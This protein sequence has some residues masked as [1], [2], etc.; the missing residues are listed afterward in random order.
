MGFLGM[1]EATRGPIV[2]LSLTD[3]ANEIHK[4][5]REKPIQ[6]SSGPLVHLKLLRNTDIPSKI[7]HDIVTY[8]LTG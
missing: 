2:S 6:P 7:S 4:K 1:A 5:K 8:N 3:I